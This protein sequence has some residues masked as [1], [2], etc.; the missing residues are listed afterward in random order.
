MW[1]WKEE[2]GFAV[3]VGSE[4]APPPAYVTSLAA[5]T[6][7]ECATCAESFDKSEKVAIS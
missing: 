6:E 2:E 5:Q 1:M 3:D 7:T 4:L